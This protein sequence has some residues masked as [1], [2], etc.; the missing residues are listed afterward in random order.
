LRSNDDDDSDDSHI[1]LS[2]IMMMMM[3]MIMYERGK[4][5]SKPFSQINRIENKIEFYS[6]QTFIH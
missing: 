5:K 3:M 1:A 4:D 2:I 6:I